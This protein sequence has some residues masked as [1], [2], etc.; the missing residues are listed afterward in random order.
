MSYEMGLQGDPGWNDW[1]DAV[2]GF[3]GRGEASLGASRGPSKTAAA[4]AVGF[5][6]GETEMRPRVLDRSAGPRGARPGKL[7]P[8]LLLPGVCPGPAVISSL[9]QLP[10]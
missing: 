10:T 4:A 8:L 1:V 6:G 2:L 3:P 5:T 7:G 9:P